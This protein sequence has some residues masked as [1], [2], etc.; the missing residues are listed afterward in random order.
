MSVPL[1]ASPPEPPAAPPRDFRVDGWLVEASCNRIVRG[2]RTIHVRPQLIDV[3]A[4]LAARPGEVVSK[5]QLL[6]AVWSDRYIAES[7]VARCMAEL[8]RL[9]ADDA[10]QPRIIETIRKRG[11]RLITPV[12]CSE[13]RRASVTPPARTAG[14]VA[15]RPPLAALARTVLGAS[16]AMWELARQLSRR[17]A[18]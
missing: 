4:C 10:R 2:D 18:G 5:E 14:T 15:S 1:V 13:A 9:L 12:E 11:Y 6:S 16:A 7:G 8:R 17:V 3:L